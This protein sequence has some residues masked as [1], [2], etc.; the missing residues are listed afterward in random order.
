MCPQHAG[1]GFNPAP[2]SPPVT[3]AKAAY[4]G[5]RLPTPR[6]LIGFL[7]LAALTVRSGTFVKE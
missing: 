4:M 1:L 5:L 6:T 2:L 7:P 3:V